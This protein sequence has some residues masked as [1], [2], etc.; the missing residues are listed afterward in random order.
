MKIRNLILVIASIFGLW[1]LACAENN[2]LLFDGV[3][4][5]VSIPGHESLDITGALT[6]EAHIFKTA[7]PTNKRGIVGKWWN[8]T[9]YQEARS[10]DLLEEGDDSQYKLSFSVSNDGSYDSGRYNTV[11]GTT[12]LELNTWYHVAAVFVPGTSITLYVNGIKDTELTSGVIG[13]IYSNHDAPLAI[14][15]TYDPTVSTRLFAGC[16]DEVRIWNVARSEAEI[17]NNMY[18]ELTS[19]PSEL[20]GYWKLNGIAPE[21]TAKDET[22][23]QND[24]TLLPTGYANGPQW[25]PGNP[26][27]PVELSYFNATVTSQYFVLLHWMSHTETDMLGYIVLRS[28]D[29]NLEHAQ[30]V[31]PLIHANNS[32]EPVS[33]SFTDEE[34]FAGEWYYWLQSIDLGGSHRFHGPTFT[35]VNTGQRGSAPAIDFEVG[36]S[37]IYPNPFNPSVTIEYRL[38]DDSAGMLK[39]YNTRGQL[40]QTI[41]LPAASHSKVMEA[42]D[43]A[44]G[45]Y[46]FRL[47]TG[48]KVYSHKAVLSK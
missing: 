8:Y 32:S 11:Y 15:A 4:D 13:F 24:G 42:T 5:Y 40:V 12:V 18:R 28:D 37:N 47:E 14:G 16:I 43:L 44:A 33:Y 25:T 7:N 10:Y 17:Q 3:N 6:I 29:I 35:I 38:A 1:S 45:V 27:L 22:S 21:Q 23:N 36:F 26:T 34:V 46:L 41:K 48:G 2:A 31:S 20:V 30:Q 9:D 19:L 39:V